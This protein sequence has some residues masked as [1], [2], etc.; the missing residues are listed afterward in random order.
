L[1]EV[2]VDNSVKALQLTHTLS[3]AI[4][5]RTLDRVVPKGVLRDEPGVPGPGNLFEP[6]PEWTV[7]NGGV[8]AETNHQAAGIACRGA[9]YVATAGATLA[10]ALLGWLLLRKGGALRR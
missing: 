9:R 2:V 8:N 3:P 5:E 7:T 6:D 4:Y 1:G 10:S